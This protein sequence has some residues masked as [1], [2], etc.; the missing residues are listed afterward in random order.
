VVSPL[1]D[2]SKAD[3]IENYGFGALDDTGSARNL[4]E[5]TCRQFTP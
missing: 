3:T 2:G 4:A 5:S 1:C